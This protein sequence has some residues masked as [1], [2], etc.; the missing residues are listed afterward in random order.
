MFGSSALW[1][2]VSEGHA[3][4]SAAVWGEVVGRVRT[5]MT[6]SVGR[7]SVVVGRVPR[8]AEEPAWGA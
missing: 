3:V 2:S 7:A 5:G 6:A 1:G 4:V 8:A